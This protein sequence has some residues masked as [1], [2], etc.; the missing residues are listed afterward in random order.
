M[1]VINHNSR[2][3]GSDTLL[4]A[5]RHLNGALVLAVSGE[6]DLANVPSLRARLKTATETA[7]N[8]VVVDLSGL[9]YIDL[10]GI[11]ALLEARRTFA[12]GGR[13]IVLAAASPL[14]QRILEILGLERD[15][16]VFLTVDTAVESFRTGNGAARR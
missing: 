11:N 3:A 4:A 2:R 8:L 1:V 7:K 15:L 14:V 6:L 13:S 9:R 10:S 5:Q 16:P 12:R